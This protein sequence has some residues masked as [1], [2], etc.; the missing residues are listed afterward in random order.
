M[1]VDDTAATQTILRRVLESAGHTVRIAANGLAAIPQYFERR[2]DVILMDVQM[3]VLDG[4]KTT[5]ILRV[6]ELD[7]PQVPIIIVTSENGNG[8]RDQCLAAGADEYVPK[9]FDTQN[10]PLLIGELCDRASSHP[11]VRTTAAPL[12]YLHPPEPVIDL[13]SALARLGGDK[14]LLRELVGFFLEDFPQLVR[15]ERD[16]LANA[17]WPSVQRASHSL[18]GL[19]ANFTAVPAVRALQAVET[20]CDLKN[21]ETTGKLMRVANIEIGRLLSA[22]AT[23]YSSIDVDAA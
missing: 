9:P 5:Q 16:G 13:P 6:F 21:A 18:K 11:G 1:V 8:Y 17:N 15:T 12:K 3:P 19:A 23:E 4:L 2:P 14:R 20:S 22:L 10:I 7:L